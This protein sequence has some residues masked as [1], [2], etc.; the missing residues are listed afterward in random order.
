VSGGRL[1]A[2]DLRL[3]YPFWRVFFVCKKIAYFSE[4]SAETY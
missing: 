4:N 1:K 3:K 2:K